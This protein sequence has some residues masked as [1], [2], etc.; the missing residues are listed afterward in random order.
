MQNWF[1]M[2]FSLEICCINKNDIISI[3][4]FIFISFLRGQRIKNFH[5]NSL[6]FY[7][8]QFIRY[9]YEFYIPTFLEQ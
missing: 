2:E 7:S 1:N 9:D 4:N 5:E 3:C 6:I 8:F